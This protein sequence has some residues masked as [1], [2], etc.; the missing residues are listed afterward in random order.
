MRWL[1]AAVL[2]GLAT[3]AVAQTSG[4]MLGTPSMLIGCRAFVENA[5]TADMMQVGACAG[6]VSAVMDVA[7]SLRRACPPQ[8]A[9]L[10]DVTRHVIRFADDNP[11]LA[12]GPFGELALTALGDRWRC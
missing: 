8:D 3:P 10:V 4:G 2:F 1:A 11:R 5:P 6:A 7:R 12:S 9:E